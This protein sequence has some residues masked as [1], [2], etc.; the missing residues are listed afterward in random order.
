VRKWLILI[1]RYLGIALSLV[2]VMWFVSGIAMIYARDMPRLT[3]EARLERRA[4]VDLSRIQLSPADAAARVDLGQSSGRVALLTV[5]DRP[6]YRF[7]GRRPVTIFADTGDEMRELREPEILKIAG[8]FLNLPEAAVR[9]A[10]VLTSA[11]QWTIGQRGQLPLHKVTADDAARTVLYVSP[12]SGEV[13]VLTTRGSRALAWIAAIPHWLYFAPLRLNDT[14]WRQVVLWLSGLAVVSAIIGL[15]LGVIQ[16]R[17]SAPFRF[18]RVGSYIPYAGW[19]RW[20]YLTGVVFGVFS[21][22]W[23]FSGMLSMEP[24]SWA[25]RGGS[26]DGI[27]GALAGGPLDL[28]E[29]PAFN[30]AEWNRL[31]PGRTIRFQLN[32]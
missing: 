6:A 15:V 18:S 29:F 3:P 28:A 14:V 31:L 16:F 30:A 8:R 27:Y 11:D 25:S 4:A 9:H 22:T 12:R 32:R 23:A 5:M 19:M 21:V 20:H 1:H 17:P 24:W 2:F 7:S 13:A 26:G 10:G